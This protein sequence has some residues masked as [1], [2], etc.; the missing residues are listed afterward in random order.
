MEKIDG[1]RIVLIVAEDTG[2]IIRRPE[3]IFE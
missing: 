3:L 2:A 1:T